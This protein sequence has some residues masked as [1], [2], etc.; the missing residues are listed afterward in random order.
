MLILPRSSQGV[1]MHVTAGLLTYF[2]FGRLPIKNLNSKTVAKKCP[3]VWTKFT[4]AGL[5]GIFTRF[6]INLTLGTEEENHYGNKDIRILSRKDK[7]KTQIS[8]VVDKY[9]QFSNGIVESS[10]YVKK[11]L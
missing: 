5:S 2:L 7:K 4:A 6:P 8:F 10:F 9:F 11:E 1:K 3:H